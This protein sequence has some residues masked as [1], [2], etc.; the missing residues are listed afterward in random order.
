MK[1]SV[2]INTIIDIFV[3]TAAF[4]L[5]IW[6]K[7]AT[8][9]VYLPNYLPS[10]LLFLGF[11]IVFS[12]ITKKYTLYKRNDAWKASI[13]VI[14][15]NLVIIAFSSLLMF[16]F[17]SLFYSRLVVFGTIIF[18]TF[19]E[20]ILANI[21]CYIHTAPDI[22]KDDISSKHQVSVLDDI[23][24]AADADINIAEDSKAI[25]NIRDAI[26]NESGVNAYNFIKSN[27]NIYNKN[28]I[29]L[30]TIYKFNIDSLSNNDINGI[31]N[32]Q[33]INDI[34]Y[35]NKFFE[36][37]NKKISVSGNFI[38]CVE[39]KNLRKIRILKKY[40]PVLN[41]IYYTFDYILKRVFP[42]FSLTKKIY[43][44]FTRGQNRVISLAE[45]FGRLYSCGFDVVNYEKIN[46]LL[47][48]IS[49]KIKNPVY[50]MHPTYG[51]LIKLRRIGKNGK[52]IYVYKMRTM[53]PYA[54]YLQEYIYKMHDL[55]KG[56]KFHNDFRVTMIGRF[57]RKFWIDELPMLINFFKG[58]MKIVGV[59]PLS[60][61]YFNLYSK[62]LQELRVKVKPGLVPP[63]Y[64]DIPKTIEEIQESELKYLRKHM[65]H[66]IRT[67]WVYFWKA[68]WNIVVKKARSN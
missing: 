12:L 26:I 59:R 61:Q 17:Q 14:T 6:L 49:R 28:N 36:S 62:E 50:D 1:K 67:D 57:M 30:S 8:K 35:I 33:R 16:A 13:Y 42:K 18:T 4:M 44:L 11:W 38:G 47:F 5:M 29:V 60:E 48:F 39:T 7:P 27:I 54:E 2:I 19:F 37:I 43:F 20:I 68:S 45:T 21:S 66:P 32:L 40:P 52:I 9:R 23:L 41:Y 55:E 56:G 22:Q 46:G 31:V 15:I 65:K 3:L 64:A 34:R 58:E 24:S 25:A 53:H 10:F 51:P 63:F